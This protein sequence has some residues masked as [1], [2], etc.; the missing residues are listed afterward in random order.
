MDK[1]EINVKRGPDEHWS[2]WFQDFEVSW[3]ESVETLLVGED[4]DQA[5]LYGLIAKLR[6]LSL[7]SIAA[8]EIA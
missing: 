3:L 5:A 8:N 7:T 4:V 2:D 1:I 6:D